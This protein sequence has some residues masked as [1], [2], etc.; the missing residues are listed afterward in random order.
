MNPVA[1]LAAA[2]L[3]VIGQPAP[4][5]TATDVKGQEVSLADFKGKVVVLEWNNFDCPF[6]KKHYQSGNLPKLQETY[7]D[8]GV[9]WLTVNSAAEGKQGYLEPSKMAEKAAAEGNKAAHYLMDTDGKVGKAFGAKVTPHMFIVNKDGALVYDGAMD[10]KATPKAEDIETAEPLF[11]NALDAVLDGKEV[12]DSKN[13]P[14]GCG[15]KY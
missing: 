1:A 7:A 11:T 13:K 15:V 8:K 2:V 12:S 5:F 14:Y 4:S 3:A 9:V 6:V 10:S